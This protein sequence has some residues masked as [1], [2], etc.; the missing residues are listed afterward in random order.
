LMAAN[1]A[2]IWLPL[3]AR[4][5]ATRWVVHKLNRCFR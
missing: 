2:S 5:D 3:K 1:R 4:L